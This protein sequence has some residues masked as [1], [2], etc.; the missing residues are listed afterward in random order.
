VRKTESQSSKAQLLK[1]AVLAC[2]TLAVAAVLGVSDATAQDAEKPNDRDSKGDAKKDAPKDAAK[3]GA[4]NADNVAD[5]ESV[6]LRDLL[7]TDFMLE[8]PDGRAAEGVTPEEAKQIEETLAGGVKALLAMQDVEGVID[9]YNRSY[10]GQVATEKQYVTGAHALAVWALVASGAKTSDASVKSAVKAMVSLALTGGKKASTPNQKANGGA[11]LLD[12]Y[13]LSLVMMAFHA[14]AVERQREAQA[15]AEKKASGGDA[16]KKAKGARESKK[17]E[18]DERTSLAAKLRAAELLKQLSVSEVAC[19]KE[20]SEAILARQCGDGGW[21]YV[22]G[23]GSSDPSNVHFATL[24]LLAAFRVGLG[25]PKQEVLDKA[26][27]FWIRTQ[28]AD[29]PRVDLKFRKTDEDKSDKDNK[30]GKESKKSAERPKPKS[31]TTRARGW[32]YWIGTYDPKD[33]LFSGREL[34]MTAAGVI[35]LGSL[36]HLMLGGAKEGKGAQGLRDIDLALMDGLACLGES[37]P[38][39]DPKGEVPEEDKKED[40]KGKKRDNKKKGEVPPKETPTRF[41]FLDG[42]TGLAVERAGILMGCDTFGRCEWY[43]FGARR[44]LTS[45][46]A[47]RDIVAESPAEGDEKKERGRRDRGRQGDAAKKLPTLDTDDCMDLLF[48]KGYLDKTPKAPKG[49]VITGGGKPVK[50]GDEEPKPGEPKAG[51]PKAG[52]PKPDAPK[53]ATP[54]APEQP[55]VPPSETPKQPETP[56][57]PDEPA[58]PKQPEEPKQPDEPKQ[59]PQD[60]PIPPGEP[61]LD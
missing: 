58:P 36:R 24:G 15:E 43:P 12:T 34:S 57:K 10:E 20:V 41:V 39:T 28:H 50:E 9:T 31:M 1:T 5:Y 17:K 53:P 35:C 51:E 16:G 56:K 44:L 3:D 49:P 7:T 26:S 25:V 32:S 27:K 22:H 4:A 47:L 61:P 13:E 40:D 6:K 29:G 8:H 11:R 60:D 18:I 46:Y 55:K 45:H 2:V 54:P 52:E 33:T 21:G 37:L 59:P 42:Y 38:S 23:D 30:D 19:A 14:I 48:L